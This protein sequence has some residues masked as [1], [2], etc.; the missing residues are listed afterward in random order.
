MRLPSSFYQIE[1]CLQP[2][3]G[4]LSPA[5][6][7]GLALWVYGTLL[8]ASACQ[9]AVLTALSGLASWHTLRQALR[10]WLY[11]GQDKAAPCH[12]QLPV[13]AG[14]SGLIRWFVSLWTEQRVFLALDA[15]GHRDRLTVLTLSVLY[16]GSAV[17]LVWTVLPGN[18]PGAWN[19]HWTAML[20]FLRAGLP[21]SWQVLVLCDRGLWSP[22]LFAAICALGWHPLMRVQTN[23]VFTPH[24]KARGPARALVTGTN[25][26]WIGTGTA[27]SQPANHLEASL[28]V[29][30][31]PGQKEPSLV[32]TDLAPDQV[33][34]LWYGLRMWVEAGFRLL[35]SAGWQWHKT[36]RTD[37]ARAARHWLV[38]AVATLWTLACGTQQQSKDGLPATGQR[39]SSLLR[40][41]LGALQRQLGRGRVGKRLR[42]CPQPLPQPA[43]EL[44]VV[45]HRPI[46]TG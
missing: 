11:D 3:F 42:L 45:Y 4:L 6:Q 25:Q 31:L 1:Q 8:A 26:A 16:N 29:L 23:I 34:V 21:D 14:C 30:W 9:N 18:Q 10:E 44:Q 36:R 33:G 19:P 40:R 46:D 27:F 13:Q 15:T 35:K 41:G 38:L 2:Q 28:I 5:Q 7:R 32:L 12:T 20:Q 43:P 39:H 22:D 17:P 24:R 37:C